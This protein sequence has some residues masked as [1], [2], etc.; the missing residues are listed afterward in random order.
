VAQCNSEESSEPAT[1]QHFTCWQVYQFG[2]DGN[3]MSLLNPH[4]ENHNAIARDC[5]VSLA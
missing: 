3:D 4:A 1:Y 2:G 5:R